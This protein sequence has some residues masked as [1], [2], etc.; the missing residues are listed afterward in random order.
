MYNY[1]NRKN[2]FKNIS[3]LNN[4]GLESPKLEKLTIRVQN[5]KVPQGKL[6]NWKD[7]IEYGLL[8]SGVEVDIII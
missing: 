5:T 3:P 8:Y 7:H 2:P 1:I 6:I 4:V